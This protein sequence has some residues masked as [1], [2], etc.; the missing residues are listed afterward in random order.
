MFSLMTPIGDFVLT[1]YSRV[2]IQI[3]MQLASNLL[4]PVFGEYILSSGALLGGIA[5]SLDTHQSI[6]GMFTSTAGGTFLFIAL[7]ELLP[8][9][10]K[11][12]EVIPICSCC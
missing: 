11:K 6:T 9:A 7:N 5:S 10:F 1:H 2:D 8:K 12:Q 3:A 4:L